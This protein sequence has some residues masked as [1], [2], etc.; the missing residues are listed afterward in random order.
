MIRPNLRKRILVPFGDYRLKVIREKAFMISQA[1]EDANVEAAASAL[2]LD[3]FKRL[4]RE[5]KKTRD[6]ADSGKL[7]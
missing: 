7:T 6:D 1:L 5:G 2:G 4:L 3:G